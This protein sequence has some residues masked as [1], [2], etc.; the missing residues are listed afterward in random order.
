[1]KSKFYIFLLLCIALTACQTSEWIAPAYTDVPKLSK[2]NAG[3]KVE[4]VNRALGIEPYNIYH[5]QED[6][7]SVLTY[8]YRI[9]D[10]KMTINAKNSWDKKY[11]KTINGED[12]AQTE[13][14]TW[15]GSS[16]TAYIL[17]Q[18]GKVRSVITD[19]GRQ[20]S[21]YLLITNN[22]IQLIAKDGISDVNDSLRTKKIP[23]QSK[24]NS[25]MPGNNN[26]KKKKRAGV[27]FFGGGDNTNN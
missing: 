3:M 25:V 5:I 27:T 23:I 12:R 14:S 7:S 19:A 15:Y 20:D 26:S 24:K 6:G 10:R 8:N 17:F 1:M 2:I 9:K 16:Y 11:Q 18:N 21:E 13:G 22:T 4:D